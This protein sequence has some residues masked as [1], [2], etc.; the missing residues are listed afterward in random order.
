MRTKILLLLFMALLLGA[1]SASD[2]EIIQDLEFYES[3][4]ALENE[5]LET[6]QAVVE[7]HEVEKENK[8]VDDDK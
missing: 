1:M 2:A 8:E 4:N 3:L 6:V 7:N 5:D